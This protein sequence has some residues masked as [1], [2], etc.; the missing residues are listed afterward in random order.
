MEPLWSQQA[1]PVATGDKSDD[2]ENRS[3]KP[4]RNRWQPTAT[5]LKRMVTRRSTRIAS[6]RSRRRAFHRHVVY[7]GNTRGP[8][9]AQTST[10]RTAQPCVVGSPSGR[11]VPASKAVQRRS[12]PSVAVPDSA[13]HAGGRGFESRRSRCS[14]CPANKR[15]SLPEEARNALLRAANGQHDRQG[16]CLQKAFSGA[17]SWPRLWDQRIRPR[18]P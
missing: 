14:V 1:Q 10:G 16:K 8:L 13:C 3:N 17:G 18:A 5:V 12:S 15:L 11:K 2:P 4:I 9:V 6:P 7:G